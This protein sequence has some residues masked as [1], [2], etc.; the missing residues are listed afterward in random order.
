VS[1]SEKKL[2][3]TTPIREDGATAREKSAAAL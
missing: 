1:V 2:L 3:A